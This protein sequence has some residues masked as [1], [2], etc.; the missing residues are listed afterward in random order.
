MNT[1]ASIARAADAVLVVV[2]VQ[3]RLSA[4]MPERDAIVSAAS[5]LM[6]TAALVGVPVVVTRQN[7]AGLGDIEPALRQVA[8]SLA[9]ATDVL[10]A[11]KV[12]FD[13]FGEPT[14]VEALAATGRTQLLVAGME[15]HICVVQTVLSGISRGLDVH[16]VGDGCCSR[17]ASSHGSALDRLRHAGAVVTTTESVLYELVGEAATEQFRA[18]LRIV[19]E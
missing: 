10:W 4:V 2:D 16:V 17:S 12:A 5:K 1:S 13:C 7:P 14:F 11:D 6:R 3:E 15:T 19:K 18:L 8:E 9:T